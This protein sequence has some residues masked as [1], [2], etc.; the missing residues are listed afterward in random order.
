MSDWDPTPSWEVQ[1]EVNWANIGKRLAPEDRAQVI[2]YAYDLIERKRGSSA[3]RDRRRLIEMKKGIESRMKAMQKKE[4]AELKRKS[5]K[6]KKGV[7]K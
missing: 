4:A 1:R 7:Q 2:R 3:M 6:K 5:A